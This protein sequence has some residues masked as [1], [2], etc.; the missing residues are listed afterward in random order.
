MPLNLKKQPQQDPM[1]L[2]PEEVDALVEILELFVTHQKTIESVVDKH[3]PKAYRVPTIKDLSRL[4]T[5]IVGKEVG[6]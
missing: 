2:L 3:V 1:Y 4:F 6:S 5:N